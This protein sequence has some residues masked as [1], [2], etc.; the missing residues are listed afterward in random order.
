MRRKIQV[1]W[2]KF[3]KSEQYE[4]LALRL[5]SYMWNSQNL[6]PK[7]P[8]EKFPR[9]ICCTMEPECLFF[10][11]ISQFFFQNWGRKDWNLKFLFNS[12]ISI[13]VMTSKETITISNYVLS[14]QGPNWKNPRKCFNSSNGE[15]RKIQLQTLKIHPS[16][17]AGSKK[18]VVQKSHVKAA[19]WKY[20]CTFRSN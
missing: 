8:L 13:Y 19:E 5:V 14:S 15:S 16:F 10:S 20:E 4:N 18:I 17:K 2:I 11:L 9:K 6:D 3:V 7:S 1:V 12:R